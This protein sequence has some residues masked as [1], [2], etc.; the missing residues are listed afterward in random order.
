VQDAKQDKQNVQAEVYISSFL[1]FGS[2]FF[3]W[4]VQKKHGAEEKVFS[5]KVSIL[6]DG[7]G[8]NLNFE[9]QFFKIG[10]IVIEL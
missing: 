2:T 4:V 7:G 1:M 9:L 3:Y 5:K 8:S 6:L 10:V